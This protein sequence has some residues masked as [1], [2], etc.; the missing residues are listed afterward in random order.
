M[1]RFN[2]TTNLMEYYN[3][4][5]WVSII[6][7]STGPGTLAGSIVGYHF[8]LDKFEY[9]SWLGTTTKHIT[10]DSVQ[11]IMPFNA[12]IVAITYSCDIIDSDIQL[13]IEIAAEGDGATNSTAYSWTVNDARVARV[14]TLTGAGGPGGTVLTAGTKIGVFGSDPG[15]G[16]EPNDVVVSVY[17]QWTDEIEEDDVE[18]YTGNFT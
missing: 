17:I 10:S 2:D 6:G 11:Y 5:I 15:G 1:M 9:D 7:N 4:T 16:T 12:E 13:D 14:S 3:G 8:L 18:N